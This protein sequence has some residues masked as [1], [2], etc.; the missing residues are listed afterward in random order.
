MTRPLRFWKPLLAVSVLAV[1]AGGGLWW[2]RTSRPDYLL[3]RGRLALRQKNLDDAHHFASKLK[4]AGHLEHAHLLLGEIFYST[5]CFDLAEFEL[6]QIEYQSPF[7]PDAVTRFGY[8]Q[9]MRED[10][11]KN[12]HQAGW[13][14]RRAIEVNPDHLEAHRGLADILY[15]QGAMAL[16]LDEM[17]IIARIDPRDGRPLLFMG[18]LYADVNR[19]YESIESYEEALKRDL[20]SEDATTCRKDL[21]E[22]LVKNG[23][24]DRGLQLLDELAPEVQGQ[25]QVVA[26]RAECLIGLLRQ[27]EALALLDRALG[28]HPDAQ[29]LLGVAGRMHLQS[30]DA[31]AAVPLLERAL[32]LDP[33]DQTNNHYLALAYEG[34]G[35]RE[36]AEKQRRRSQQVKEDLDE[37][38]RLNHEAAFSPWDAD[39]RLRLAEV[40]QRLGKPQLARMWRDAAAACRGAQERK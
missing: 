4:E 34:T 23:G 8:C 7:F 36:Q 35:R 20:G 1:L 5:R 32:A 25:P 21:A 6:T 22:V 33:Y 10:R 9:M 30:G 28:K 40:T 29:P 12:L 26:L 39:L 14:F 18:Q 15:N 38:T 37:M 27:D 13:A 3:E 19:K 31:E 17:K 2:Y 16:A 24:Y 11:H